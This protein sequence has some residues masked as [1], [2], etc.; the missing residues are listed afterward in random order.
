MGCCSEL[1]GDRHYVYESLGFKTT[2][3]SFEDA[4]LYVHVDEDR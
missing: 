2:E 4:A 3:V 1:Q